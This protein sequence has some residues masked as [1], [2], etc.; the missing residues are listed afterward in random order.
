MF[1]VQ[2]P[3]VRLS[4]RKVSLWRNSLFRMQSLLQKKVSQVHFPAFRENSLFTASG[5]AE[6]TFVLQTLCVQ[7]RKVS[8]SDSFYFQLK[9]STLP[10]SHSR[11][12]KRYVKANRLI[13][14]ERPTG[15][16]TDDL[17][18][19]IF[20][21]SDSRGS[22]RA[23]RM[24]KCLDTGMDPKRSSPFCWS[25]KDCSILRCSSREEEATAF[26]D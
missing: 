8:S 21:F 11:A 18:M 6:H 20:L 25:E 14:S 26:V 24:Q 7:W 15:A 22:C 4:Q 13:A 12:L 9:T 10:F 23:C 1:V 19:M 2:L 3:S 5:T 17:K 16:L